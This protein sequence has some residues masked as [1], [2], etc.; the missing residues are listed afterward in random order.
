M[1]NAEHLKILKKG[2]K[3]WNAWRQE[4]R[5][6][7]PD[8]YGADLSRMD[9]TYIHIMRTNLGDANLSGTILRKAFA[10]GTYFHGA[11]MTDAILEGADMRGCHLSEA[12][13]AGARM[14]GAVLN[15]ALA[16][17]VD[18]SDCDMTSAMML[19]TNLENSDFTGADMTD[20]DLTDARLTGIVTEGVKGYRFRR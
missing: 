16:V 13:L 11:D 6:V 14:A 18:F 20:V 3:A 19:G 1:A 5:D 17:G 12:R 2:V 10:V 15:K 9:L 4:N 8:L 7:V